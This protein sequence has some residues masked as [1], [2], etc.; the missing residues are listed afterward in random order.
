MRAV[1]AVEDPARTQLC[2][3][4]L[5]RRDARDNRAFSPSSKGANVRI[6]RPLPALRYP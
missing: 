5:Q 1:G 4:D 6:L 2:G 3:D